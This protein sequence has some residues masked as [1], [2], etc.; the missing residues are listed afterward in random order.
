MVV[1]GVTVGVLVPVLCCCVAGIE[2][3]AGGYVGLVATLDCAVHMTL[4]GW[5][6]G[7]V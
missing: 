1:C 4:W 6:E 5:F 7:A 3:A 2:W